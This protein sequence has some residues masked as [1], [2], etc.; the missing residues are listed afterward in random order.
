[1][2]AL[3]FRLFAVAAD[4][5]HVPQPDLTNDSVR[6]VLRI[7]FGIAGGVAVIIVIVSGLRF[8]TSQGNP[9]A[10]NKA[11]N[12]VVYAILGL[13]VTALRDRKSVV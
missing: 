8:V 10:T 13:V 2:Q 7:V 5:I 3:L 12:S 1:M 9:D 6:T 11:R 4:S